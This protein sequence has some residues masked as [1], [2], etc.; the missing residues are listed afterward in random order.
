MKF[1]NYT[2]AF[3]ELPDEVSLAFVVTGCPR[4]CPGCHSPEQRSA[5]GELLTDSLLSSLINKYKRH[6]TCVLF[7][8][9]EF[10]EDEI[11]HYA[12]IVRSANL[13]A[14]L[15]SGAESLPESF[16]SAFDYVKIGP[17]NK[18]LG[19]LSSPKTNQRLYRCHDSSH[20]EDITFKFYAQATEK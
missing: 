19:G 13:L 18:E 9:G 10:L 2:I 16:F 1:L 7:M 12:S 8:G 4:N 20:I 14:G 5:S 15:Y 3:Q 17:Y 11:L 6:I